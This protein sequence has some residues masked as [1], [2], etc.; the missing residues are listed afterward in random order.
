MLL[1]RISEDHLEVPPEGLAHWAAEIIETTTIKL[2]SKRRKP[3]GRITYVLAGITRRSRWLLDRAELVDEGQYRKT[4]REFECLPLFKAVL[5][6]PLV[7]T[8]EEW[9]RYGQGGPLSKSALE[10]GWAEPSQR[11]T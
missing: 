6:P 4:V 7:V 9:R 1:K 5:Y 8:V 11:T 10:G 3:D 2:L